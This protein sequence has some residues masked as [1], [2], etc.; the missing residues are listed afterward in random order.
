MIKIM[1]EV[2][3][4]YRMLTDVIWDKMGVV[5]KIEYMIMQSRLW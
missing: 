2:R 4:A 3:L 5:V 1:C